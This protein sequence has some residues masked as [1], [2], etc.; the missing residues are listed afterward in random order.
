MAL[1]PE[2]R[3]QMGSKN[4]TASNGTRRWPLAREFRFEMKFNEFLEQMPWT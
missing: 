3:R 4:I 1:G 2:V